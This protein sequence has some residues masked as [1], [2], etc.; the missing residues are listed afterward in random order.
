MERLS[1]IPLKYNG[2]GI[3]WLRHLKVHGGDIETLWYCLFTDQEELKIFASSCSK[4]W[5]IVESNQW[6]NLTEETG[7]DGWN[8]T[9]TLE[10]RIKMSK[11][12]IGKIRTAETKKKIQETL[13]G[14]SHSV[15]RIAN[16]KLSN[17]GIRNVQCPHCSIV[18]TY[19]ILSRWHF[20]KCKLKKEFK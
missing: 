19:L 16:F 7:L 14:K 20:D 8:G 15:E 10:S 4:L 5:N 11:S 3:H 6:L 2:S 12:R 17:K 9:H 13:K 18:G 1:N